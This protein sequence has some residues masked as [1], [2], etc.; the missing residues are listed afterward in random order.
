MSARH[1]SVL[2]VITWDG[3]CELHPWVKGLRRTG[4]V[5]C[6]SAQLRDNT[7]P[8]PP[9][10]PASQ[11][12]ET[13]TEANR[14]Y[15]LPVTPDGWLSN[16]PGVVFFMLF[17]HFCPSALSLEVLKDTVNAFV[18][19]W[20]TLCG[21]SSKQSFTLRGKT[22]HPRVCNPT[23]LLTEGRFLK[24][25][26]ASN[27]YSIQEKRSNWQSVQ[28]NHLLVESP[29]CRYKFNSLSLHGSGTCAKPSPV[30][31]RDHLL[32]KRNKNPPNFSMLEVFIHSRV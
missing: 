4:S 6:L 7:D 1:S 28:C 17:I 10:R 29:K 32:Q 11:G 13:A 5:T 9:H 19:H 2:S 23:A 21:D 27:R 14:R 18:L 12:H 20:E 22:V 25:S 15:T 24:T 8:T 16:Y 3:S 30:G 31:I 26:S